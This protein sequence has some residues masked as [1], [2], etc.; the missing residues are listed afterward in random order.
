MRFK[1]FFVLLFPLN[2]FFLSTAEGKFDGFN[3][4]NKFFYNVESVGALSPENIVFSGLSIL[5]KKLSDL[6]TQHSHE[7]QAQAEGLTI[8]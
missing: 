4:P 3:A 7:A 8:T 1:F 2:I 6:Q 5:K